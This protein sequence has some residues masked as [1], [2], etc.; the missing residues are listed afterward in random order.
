MR[1]YH[2]LNLGAGVQS[3][4]IYLMAARG[5]Y[6]FEID[7][8][9]FADTQVEP[10]AVYDH[11]EWLRKQDGPEILV[12]TAG[13]LGS[14]LIEGQN[15]TGQ[16][17]APIPAFTAFKRGEPLGMVRR[18]CTREYKVDVVER[19]IRRNILGLKPRQR[20]P[21]GVHIHHYMGFSFDEAG[22]AS[23]TKDRFREIKWADVHFPLFDDMMKRADCV[24]WL[25][26]NA[27]V[28][29]ETPRSACV[30][31]PFRS[32]DEWRSLRKSDEDWEAACEVD[33]AL[34]VDGNIVNRNMDAK[35][36]VHRSCVPLREA[37]LDDNQKSL[38]D[39]ECEGGCGL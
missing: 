13:N 36:Y 32:N 27:K 25:E 11:L 29:H 7:Y 22:R 21:A 26:E 35:L 10:V 37:N 6:D 17:F 4:T 28:P 23:R 9:I 5:M 38:F 20:I 3:T 24:R 12:E 33:D 8:A 34:R 14:D 30:F 39:M 1:E 18:Q 31:C 16:S 19:T 15:S 2:I